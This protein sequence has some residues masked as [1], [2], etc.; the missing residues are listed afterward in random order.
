[1]FVRSFVRSFF[2]FSLSL[3]LTP[4]PSNSLDDVWALN[5][6]SLVW[7]RLSRP[8]QQARGGNSVSPHAGVGCDDKN[9]GGGEGVYLGAHPL[10]PP[11]SYFGMA[12]AYIK[13]PR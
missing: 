6:T 9:F 1:M 2:F 10:I 4:R 8:A 5:L 3:G 11:A 7:T 12:G 13:F